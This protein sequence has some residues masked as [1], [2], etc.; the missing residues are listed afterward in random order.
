M[1]GHNYLDPIVYFPILFFLL[2]WMGD[3]DF[4]LGYQNVPI[5]QWNLYFIG[6]I[7]FYCGSLFLTFIK[8]KNP[9]GVFKNQYIS[10]DASII[11]FI[12]FLIC[13][14]CKLLIYK[15][16]GIPVLSH[17]VDALRESAAE[18]FGFLKVI[19]SA[20][21]IITV[22]YICDLM[23]RTN[24]HKRITILSILVIILSLTISILDGSRLLIVQMA[25]PSLF[26]FIVKIKRIKLSKVIIFIFLII[27]FIGANKFIRN[28]MENPDYLSYISANRSDSLFSNIMLSGFASF[29]VGI[30]CLRQLINIVPNYSNYTHG[31]MFLNSILTILPGKQVI[32]GYYV[33]DLLGLNFNGIGAATTMI[34]LFYLDGGPILVFV[35]MMLFGLLVEFNY[36]KYLK[37]SRIG[38]YNLLPIYIAYY[39]I[40]CL[41][42]NV[43]PNI[44]PI[45]TAFYYIMIGLIIK[46]VGTKEKGRQI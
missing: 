23:N 44:D 28:I 13:I 10:H 11:I 30:D 16:N 8:T 37:F 18:N 29:R 6:I 21:T 42:T 17:N 14:I 31:Q 20:Y 1:N 24:Q 7:G 34:G 4:G 46:H 41:R 9:Q 22:Y 35:G 39:S 36:K 43:L 26:Y 25:I 5:S 33:A 45:L 38:L 32:I 27:L 19:S 12:I 40:Y 2:Y 3:F 15:T